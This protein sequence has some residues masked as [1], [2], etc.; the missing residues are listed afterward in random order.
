MYQSKIYSILDIFFHKANL[1]SKWDDLEYV[2]FN[3]EELRWCSI[4]KLNVICKLLNYI[5]DF[6][7]WLYRMKIGYIIFIE[8]AKTIANFFQW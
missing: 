3:F 4:T 6:K 7:V 8:L 2:T 5:V 1:I